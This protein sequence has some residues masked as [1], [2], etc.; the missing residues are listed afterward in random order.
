MYREGEAADRQ[1]VG[2]WRKP[3]I[4]IQRP[5]KIGHGL[6][7]PNRPKNTKAGAH[8]QDTG[9][10]RSSHHPLPVH[11]GVPGGTGVHTRPPPVSVGYRS[12]STT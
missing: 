2:S 10:V 7:A 11:A 9:Q 12:L 4:D 8:K 1:R 5:S 3:E 6:T